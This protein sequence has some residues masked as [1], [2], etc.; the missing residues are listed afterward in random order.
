MQNSR[1]MVI[2]FCAMK[3]ETKGGE[4]ESVESNDRS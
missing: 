1:E 3:V 2:R 4:K